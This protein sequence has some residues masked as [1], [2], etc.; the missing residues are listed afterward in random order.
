MSQTTITDHFTR[1][2]HLGNHQSTYLG[3]N[4]NHIAP[5]HNNNRTHSSRTNNRTHDPDIHVDYDLTTITPLPLSHLDT[6]THNISNPNNPIP[7]N[8]SHSHT[9]STRGP[10]HS[11]SRLPPNPHNSENTNNPII[12]NNTNNHCNLNNHCISNKPYNHNRVD[13]C[14]NPNNPNNPHILVNNNNHNA[15]DNLNSPNNSNIS[16]DTPMLN[17]RH[18]HRYRTI[19]TL[20]IASY[21][22]TTY[23][24]N[25]TDNQGIRRQQKLFKNL[26]SLAHSSDIIMTQETKTQETNL[27][28]R[29]LLKPQWSSFNNPNTHNPQKAG[30]DIFVSKLLTDNFDIEPVV[31]V[32]G[33]IQAL[34][35]TPKTKSSL[36]TSSF[37]VINVYLISGIDVDTVL[38]RKSMLEAL[39][40]FSHTSPFVFA[41]GDW[42]LTQHES[43]SSSSNHFASTTAARKDLNMALEA[44][45]LYE[46]YQPTHTCVR[47]GE[48][49]TSSRLDRFY[50]SHSLPDKCVMHPEVTLPPHP[51]LPGCD[52]TN[53][54]PSD[55]FPIHLSFNP[56][57]LSPGSRFKIPEWIATSPKLHTAIRTRWSRRDI[58]CHAAKTWLLFKKIIKEEAL[59]FIRSHK[60][61]AQ[62]KATSLTLGISIYRGIKSNT[63]NPSQATQLA[64]QDPRLL[65]AFKSDTK[66]PHKSH[67]LPAVKKHINTLFRRN[68]L[69]NPQALKKPNFLRSAK[70]TLPH[71]RRFLSHIIS[72]SGARIEDANGMAEKLKQQWE[73]IW[74]KPNPPTSNILSYLSSYTKSLPHPLPKLSLAHLEE[75]MRRP[76]DSS[77]GP[78]G[79]PFSLYRHL[80]DIAAPILFHYTLHLSTNNKPNRSFNFT[81]LFFFPKDSTNRADKTRPISVSNTDNR[82]I[83]NTIRK[84]ITPTIAKILTPS[85]TAFVPGRSI[86]ENILFFNEKFYTASENHEN[87][88]IFFHDFSKAYDSISREYLL[89]LLRQIGLPQ[90]L[91]SL[92]EVLFLNI[93]AFPILFDSHKQVIHMT[94]GLKQGCPLSP[95][96]FNLALDPLLSHLNLIP[97]ID[98]KAYCDDIGIGFRDWQVIPNALH[99]LSAFN[100]ATGMTS[101]TK[102]TFFITTDPSPIPLTHVLPQDWRNIRITTKYK[103]LGIWFG[104]N[105]TIN[106]IFSD[107]WDKL[108]QR[109]AKYMPYK[110]HYNTQNRVII[111]NS[112]LSSIFSYLF[113]FY[114]MGEH[115]H[116]QA[117][118]LLTRWLVPANRFKYNH[119]TAPTQRAGLT[120]PLQDLYKLN[121][122][123]IL[124]NKTNIPQPNHNRG[125][126]PPIYDNHGNGASLLHQDHIQRA[127]YFFFD[128]TDTPPP[129]DTEQKDLFRIMM[130]K[131]PTP[132]LP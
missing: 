46:V 18:Y 23:G 34:I 12:T 125:G 39:K 22:T 106:D 128:L 93:Q 66:H 110:S 5:H 24:S 88:S 86:D 26:E 29:H 53:K 101:N 127:A 121:I 52:I 108:S 99:H 71:S 87:Y 94:N 129:P 13:N 114:V 49:M 92:I 51:Y 19:P 25:R 98:V 62:T 116:D 111:S 122:S 36:F 40:T 47:A 11:I 59:I 9:N 83:A 58:N 72:T 102:K 3:Y 20:R 82:I 73:P 28:Y 1:N 8:T 50:I 69:I 6:N 65:K 57:N 81:N 7:S 44:H 120:Q 70:H 115:L 2:K 56:S 107:A 119:M 113:H 118:A 123:S 85:Q 38:A 64:K 43:D 103:Y 67:N 61:K 35:F 37:T 27:I 126:Y 30:T 112:F 75:V 54:G 100:N 117:E 130:E 15:P 131:D 132:Y 79:I 80:S 95:I 55:H 33:Y 77:T 74:N 105:I 97:E 90:Y 16:L 91:I 104:N 68:P 21:N 4:N 84:I 60:H 89:T 96:L 76:R 78:D 10:L 41:G 14:N 109:V 63:L 32:E 45:N 31:I 124:R 42:N 48:Q 17:N